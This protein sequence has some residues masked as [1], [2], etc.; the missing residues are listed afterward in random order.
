MRAL[1]HFP[2]L[3]I[4]KEACMSNSNVSGRCISSQLSRKCMTV[5]RKISLYHGVSFQKCLKFWSSNVS[6]GMP[7][8]SREL[9]SGW[10]HCLSACSSYR[11]WISSLS[12]TA[13]VRSD[14]VSEEEDL[15]VFENDA[16]LENEEEDLFAHEIEQYL[17]EYSAI[18]GIGHKVFVIQPAIRWGPQKKY[19]TTPALQLAE[20]CALVDSVPGWKVAKKDIVNAREPHRKDVFGTG[21]VRELKNL[22]KELSGVTAVFVNVNILQKHQTQ[23]L[24]DLWEIPVFDRYTVIL[25][26]F[27]HHAKTKEAKLQIALA[28]VPY[29]RFRMRQLQEGDVDRQIVSSNDVGGDTFIQNRHKILHNRERKLQKI[30]IDLKK[31]REVNRKGRLKKIPTVAV[32]GYTNCGKTTL[33]KALTG[34][35]DMEP[36]DQLFATMDVTAHAGLLPNKMRAVFMDTVGF[37]TDLPTSLATA[38]AATLEDTLL[39]DVVVHVRDISHPD[40]VNQKQRVLETLEKMIPKTQLD[41]VIEVCNKAD[42]LAHI[43]KGADRKGDLYVSATSGMGLTALQEHIQQRLIANL[44]L[45]AK[46][47]RVPMQGPHLSWLYKEGTVWSADPDES[48]ENLIVHVLLS[49]ATYEKFKYHFGKV[50]VK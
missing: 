5:Y 15:Y 3:N 35:A 36:K 16:G 32:V 44:G 45:L 6:L 22:I 2:G 8:K 23:F 37:I 1:L 19:D 12:T 11:I 41:S 38:F 43:P 20:A 27:K 14:N 9:Y 29:I 28:E 18:P 49:E 46:K 39:A 26:V 47:L 4:L 7:H 30:L 42:L 50:R 33:I 40:T 48:E 31:Q 17:R 24:K 25:Q 10:P 21:K 34:D 13:T